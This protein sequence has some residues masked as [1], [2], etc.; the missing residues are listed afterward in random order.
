MV[1]TCVVTDKYG[2]RWTEGEGP[3]GQAIRPPPP[4]YPNTIF[5]FN[6]AKRRLQHV[7]VVAGSIIYCSF[8]CA[9]K[10]GNNPESMG[11]DPRPSPW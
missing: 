4:P 3:R 6:N 5:N 10:Y 1:S 8:A 11:Y 9:Y 7:G 2:Q